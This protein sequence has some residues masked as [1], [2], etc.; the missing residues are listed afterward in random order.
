LKQIAPKS[1]LFKKYAPNAN[2]Y[3]P[4]GAISPNLKMARAAQAAAREPFTT[5]TQF[6]KNPFRTYRFG[7]AL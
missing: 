6:F 4:N 3:R 5:K 2:K 1:K 7:V